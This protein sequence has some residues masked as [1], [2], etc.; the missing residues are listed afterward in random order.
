MGKL[1]TICIVVCLG[2]GGVSSAGILTLRT[3]SSDETPADVLDASIHFGVDVP[4][5][6][7]TIRVDNLTTN[8]DAYYIPQIYFNAVTRLSPFASLPT[9]WNLT[10]TESADGFGTFDY[11]VRTT[12]NN[13][14]G[15]IQNGGPLTSF[16]LTIAGTSP[17]S[18]S[19][20]DDEWSVPPPPERLAL[21]AMKF[22]RGPG[23]DS[24]FG[25]I[26]EPAT[27]AL[28]GLGSLAL[29]RRRK[30]S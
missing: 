10:S 26:P 12:N 25:A 30:N 4:T 29:L 5:L 16:T 1:I 22:V 7:L 23:D 18:Q 21:V 9:G 28:L 11:L 20:F 2:L 13:S 19:D 3:M 24:A 15:G 8:P 17:W 6:T 27:V 14:D